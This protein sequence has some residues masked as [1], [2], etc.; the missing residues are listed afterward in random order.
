ML[1][2]AHLT[3]AIN[4]TI[5]CRMLADGTSPP[6]TAVSKLSHPVLVLTLKNRR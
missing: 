3:S 6:R 2:G 4:G 5:V 1:I